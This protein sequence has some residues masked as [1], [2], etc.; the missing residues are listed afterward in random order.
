MPD[1]DRERVTSAKGPRA[2]AARLSARARIMGRA[3]ARSGGREPRCMG[4]RAGEGLGRRAVGETKPT[5][6][7][8]SVRETRKCSIG[9]RAPA[10]KRSQRRDSVQRRT[11]PMARWRSK[12]ARFARHESFDCVA[13]RATVRAGRKSARLSAARPRRFG[14]MEC[15]SLRT[16]AV[17]V[18]LDALPNGF[19]G[20][21]TTRRSAHPVQPTLP[22]HV[23]A[24]RSAGRLSVSRS[25]RGITAGRSK[26]AKSSSNQAPGTDTGRGFSKTYHGGYP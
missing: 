14:G 11:A 22:S 23:N 1:D 26:H 13:D 7:V 19:G 25:H 2:S 15:S 12:R 6:I 21:L 8:A 9:E 16:L 20:K 4:G 24:G 5:R 3:P 10:T 18:P 17:E